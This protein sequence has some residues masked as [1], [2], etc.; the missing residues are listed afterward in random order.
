MMSI[1]SLGLLLF[2]GKPLSFVLKKIGLSTALVTAISKCGALVT[3][4]VTTLAVIHLNLTTVHHVSIVGEIPAGLP[5]LHIDFINFEKWKILAPS[6]S[7]IAL[8]AYVESVAIAKVVANL[9]G[10]RINPNQELIALGFSNFA[11]AISGGMPVAGGFSRTMVNFSAGA[12]TQ[13]AMVIAALILSFAVVF[14]SSWFQNIPKAALAVIILVAVV[15]LIKIKN[16]YHTWHYDKGDG[17]AELMTFLGVLTLG[18][19]EGITLGIFLTFISHLRKTSKPHIA[20]VG[21]IPNTRHYRNINR[22]KVETWEHLL[23]M[24][25]DESITF[26]NINYIEEF[27]AQELKKSSKIKHLV[28]IFSSVSDIDMTALETLGQ[29]SS[30]LKKE[31]ITLNIAEAKGFM[32]DKLQNSDFFNQL[33]GQL[34][35]DTETAIQTLTKNTSYQEISS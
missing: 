8:I 4:V 6:A 32:L 9:H 10:E 7:F 1:T 18:I 11:T 20:V 2:F 31:S 24:R 27:I 5:S 15:P 3:I 21:R 29:L 22:H 33:N 34:F 14:C 30:Q 12:R 26:A 25:I 28:L 17:I 13:I 23:L 19:E 35:F 16:I